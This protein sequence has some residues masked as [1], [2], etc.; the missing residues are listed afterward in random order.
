MSVIVVVL[1]LVLTLLFAFWPVRLYV[2]FQCI[3]LLVFFG[4]VL[5]FFQCIIGYCQIV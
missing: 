1:S 4:C 2:F 5:Y 3:H